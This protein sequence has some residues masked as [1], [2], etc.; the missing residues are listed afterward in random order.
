MTVEEKSAGIVPCYSGR[1][2]PL[3]LLLLYPQGHW[4]FPK[5]H[6]EEKES[7]WETACRELRE[8]T[9]LS[10][11]ERMGNKTESFDYYYKLAGKLRHKTVI[12]F[13]ALVQDNN[14]TLSHEHRDYQWLTATEIAEQITYQNEISMFENLLPEFK[15][16]Y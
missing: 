12:F 15:T 1:E 9:G 14:I 4:G 10:R 2:Q 6:V 8:E 13:P 3:F 16:E 11:P 5:G 7:D